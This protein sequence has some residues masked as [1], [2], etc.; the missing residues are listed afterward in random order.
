MSWQSGG[1]F[2]S[3]MTRS[4]SFNIPLSIASLNSGPMSLEK[5]LIKW[6]LRCSLVMVDSL[7]GLAKKL[8]V[9]LVRDVIASS[10]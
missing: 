2:S 4:K 9:A 10:M 6:R 7:R 1:S 5:L 3:R 8:L